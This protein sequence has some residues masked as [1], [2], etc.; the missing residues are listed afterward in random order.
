MYCGSLAKIV[1]NLKPPLTRAS[2]SLY[3]TYNIF[4]ISNRGLYVAEKDL[5]YL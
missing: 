2:A 3:Q 1:K 5:Y 4:D